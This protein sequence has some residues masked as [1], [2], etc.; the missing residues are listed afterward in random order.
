[1]RR[2]I[3]ISFTSLVFILCASLSNFAQE[4]Q[5]KQILESF[6]ANFSS[7]TFEEQ[8]ATLKQLEEVAK[9]ENNSYH[10]NY[11]LTNI[12]DFAFYEKD[13]VTFTEY[14]EAAYQHWQ[15]HP[16]MGRERTYYTVT[17]AIALESRKGNTKKALELYFIMLSALKKDT[18]SSEYLTD[19]Y[20]NLSSEY[21]SIG[22]LESA[23]L[24]SQKVLELIDQNHS[25]DPKKHLLMGRVESTLGHIY[26]DKK[27]FQK[28]SKYYRSSISHL[29]KHK[30][31]DDYW[32]SH[33]DKLLIATYLG[34]AKTSLMIN[35]LELA[36]KA[37]TAAEEIQSKVDFQQ[38]QTLEITGQYNIQSKDYSKAQELLEAALKEAGGIFSS[39]KF[40]K[41][42]R[43]TMRMGDGKKKNEDLV[44]ALSY[45]HEALKYIDTS[46]SVNLLS[47]PKA[48]NIVHTKQALEILHKKAA[49]A[50]T[51][52]I[53]SKEEKYFDIASNSYQAAV[54]LL[55]KMKVYFLNQDTKYFIA[56]N[57]STLY[58]DYIKLLADQ[59]AASKNNVLISSIYSIAE[60]NKSAIT[61][62]ELK[63]KYALAN[64]KIPEEL[65]N[66][67]RDLKLDIAYSERILNES[68]S[69]K[70][71]DAV[72]I[73]KL[74]KK[75]FNLN[76]EFVTLDQK[77]NRDYAEELSNKESLL[78]FP[79]MQ[80]IQSKLESGDLFLETFQSENQYYFIAFDQTEHHLLEIPTSSI[81]K[82]VE[83]YID[84]VSSRPEVSLDKDQRFMD[85]SH[86]IYS[87]FLS[88]ILNQFT[89]KKRLLIV[90][91]GL[92]GS[93]P[94]ESLITDKSNPQSFLI[95]ELNITYLY[96]SHQVI[97]K[98]PNLEKVSILSL[99]PQFENSFSQVRSCDRDSL[100]SLPYAKKESE[101]L[102]QLFSG[103][104]LNSK[105]VK[106]SDLLDNIGSHDI[107]HIATHACINESNPMLN[108]IHF[109]DTYLTNSE[110]EN[111][112]ASPELIVLGA[113][114][115]ANG[116][117]IEG[118]GLLSLSKG[119]LQAGSKCIHSSL[120]AIDDYSSS[121]I[122]KGM[123][124]NLKTGKTKSEALRSSKLAFLEKA[125]GLRAHPYFWAGIIQTG[126]DSSLF[127]Q[128]NKYL[129]FDY[130]TYILGGIALLGLVLGVFYF[131]KRELYN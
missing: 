64:A 109:S 48:E 33:G 14:S 15:D 124:T 52:F 45:Y 44:S 97:D 9:S 117:Y 72:S 25:K 122:I 16:D 115:T 94:F 130:W 18:S 42:A 10:Y 85:I 37:L 59:Y 73:D 46:T 40:P 101:F 89:N 61:F 131:M 58:N 23:L 57:A 128:R 19:L 36:N 116:K 29:N 55:D 71:I 125:D 74:K 31:K 8:Y 129:S 98:K 100:S 68:N 66:K 92:L 126:E 21:R 104:F 39:K 70:D 34:L 106:K 2:T 47:N 81:N 108:E 93:I 120:W 77:L 69:V 83:E 107:I 67:H 43:I 111:Q 4:N 49:T 87:V 75:I 63:Y 22:D 99:A 76:E 62:D 51:L 56:S 86:E 95:H 1:M 121:E 78:M 105:S 12:A 113:C 88:P 96:A 90:P 27:D 65:K 11:A 32:R 5:S 50:T 80:E 13:Y 60:K 102:G 84:I 24:Y 127:E 17:K 7:T 118:E 123:F 54:E 114:H 26:R 53:D 91:D 3:I 41:E 103:T 28:A 112:L 82:K 20:S 30:Y 6:L 119:F 35:D 79:S 110:I 38:Y